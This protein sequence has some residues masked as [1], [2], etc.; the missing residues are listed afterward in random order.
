MKELNLKAEEILLVF[1]KINSRVIFHHTVLMI[2]N[3]FGFGLSMKFP[4][5]NP[6][7]NI[8]G[9]TYRLF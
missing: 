5:V 8:S 7:L 9:G 3:Q 6:C 4:A 1:S 2:N